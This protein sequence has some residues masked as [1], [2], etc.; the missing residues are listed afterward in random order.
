MSELLK[1]LQTHRQIGQTTAM[2]NGAANYDRPFFVL[3]GTFKSALEISKQSQ[4]KNAIPLGVN[5]LAELRGR[6]YPVLID[7]FAVTTEIEKINRLHD[8]KIE[9]MYAEQEGQIQ[10]IKDSHKHIE[11]FHLSKISTLHKFLNEAN[12]NL[13]LSKDKIEKL[14]IRVN[15]TKNRLKPTL[16]NLSKISLWDRIFNYKSKVS[17][18]VEDYLY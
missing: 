7:G 13:K 9:L 12:E 4:N 1:Y 6:D 11:N 3:G 16:E 17:K 18:V 2:V 15:K 10:S 14:D 5:Q 8:R